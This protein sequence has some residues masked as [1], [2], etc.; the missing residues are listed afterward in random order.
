LNLSLPIILAALFFFSA[1]PAKAQVWYRSNPSGMALERADSRMIALHHEWALSVQDAAYESLP[2]ALRPYYAGEYQIE[3]RLLYQ[4]GTIRRRQWIFRDSGGRT[5]INAS[6]PSDLSLVYSGGATEK[7]AA[8]GNSEPEAQQDDGET[9]AFVEVFNTERRL[10]ENHQYLTGGIY[11]TYYNYHDEV[12]TSSQTKAGGNT[13]WTDRYRYTRSRLLR[14]VERVFT[15]SEAA[16]QRSSALPQIAPSLKNAQPITGF[17]D[18]SPP[19]DYSMMQG[20][21]EAVYAMKA[22]RVVYNTD[23]AGRVL[24][25]I[26]YNEEDEIVAQI[27]NQWANDRI[28]TVMWKAGPEEGKIVFGYNS[29]GERMSEDDFRNGVLGRTVRKSGTLDIEEIIVNGKTVL[30]AVWDNGRKVSE[31]R[32]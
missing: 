2:E 1:A 28:S 26:H 31:E 16:D 5:R 25:E 20:A 10:V 30:R 6:L 21:L 8:G 12:L 14:A 4:R 18:S 29:K 15:N 27:E 19:F 13:L 24:S 3:Q 7:R 11:S 32:L 23:P 22:E 9:P 17:I